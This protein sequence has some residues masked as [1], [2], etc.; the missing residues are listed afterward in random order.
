MK[1]SIIVAVA[2]NRVIGKDNALPWH[3]PADM[4]Y[5]REITTGHCVLSGRKNYESIPQRFRPLPGRTNIVVTRDRSY[6]AAGAKVVHS[7]AEGVAHARQLGEAELFIIGGG[8]VFAEALPLTDKVYLTLVHHAFDGDVFF[9]PPS[10][11]DWKL[12]SRHDFSADEKNAYPYSF[13][14]LERN[15]GSRSADD[16]K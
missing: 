7:L 4:K 5:F 2:E 10:S 3:L 1:I 9:T 16:E 14:V 13:L 8:Q 15:T 6:V 12:A 11:G